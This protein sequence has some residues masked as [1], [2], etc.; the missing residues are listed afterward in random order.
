ML[1]S[2]PKKKG[3]SMKSANDKIFQMNYLNP[4][5]GQSN[6]PY[7]DLFF[8]NDFRICL[9]QL[10][11]NRDTSYH[12]HAYYEFELVVDGFGIN[13][14]MSKNIEISKGHFFFLSS[15]TFHNVNSNPDSNLTIINFKLRNSFSEFLLKLFGS[16]Y[17][18]TITLSEEETDGIRETLMSELERSKDMPSDL[19]R[20]YMQN[21]VENIL[22]IFA[23]HYYRSKE[24]NP[25]F[26]DSSNLINKVILYIRQN[27]ASHITL[28][29][30]S[31]KYG[32]SPN[33]ISQMIRSATGMTFKNY[34]NHLRMQTAYNRI[35]YQ[36]VPFKQIARDVGYENYTSFLDV[37]TKKYNIS[38]TALRSSSQENAKRNDKG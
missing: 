22:L 11:K 8:D 1:I 6:P 2:T 15:L 25:N 31:Q 14:V 36:D 4:T 10:G 19:R 29:S 26:N 17:Y 27:Y 37:F 5:P 21:A 23:Q 33:Y 13:N 20:M 3:N 24:T 38:P 28:S 35:L 32:Y 9:N 16:E 34:V 7:Q 12:T 30:V 18:A